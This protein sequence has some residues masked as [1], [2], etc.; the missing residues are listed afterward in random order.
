[1]AQGDPRHAIPGLIRLDRGLFESADVNANVPDAAEERGE[2]GTTWTLTIRQGGVV[3]SV[4][5][6]V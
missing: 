2:S 5:V 4:E 6:Y 3:M 1:M